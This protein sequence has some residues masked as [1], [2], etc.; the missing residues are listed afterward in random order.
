[1]EYVSKM[2]ENIG[3]VGNS[4]QQQSLPFPQYFQI[5]YFLRGCA[6][7]EMSGEGLILVMKTFEN[8]DLLFSTMFS[9]I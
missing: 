6:N 3:R 4:G 5:P 8:A 1:M 2:V 9:N 7:S